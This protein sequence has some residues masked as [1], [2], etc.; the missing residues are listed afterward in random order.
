M[1]RTKLDKNKLRLNAETV[2]LLQPQNLDRVH[3]GMCNSVLGT[4]SGDSGCCRTAQ[5]SEIW[6]GCPGTG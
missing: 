6:Y 4:S 5:C 2:R 3:G 1:K